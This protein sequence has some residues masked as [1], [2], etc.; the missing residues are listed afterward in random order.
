MVHSRADMPAEPVAVATAPALVTRRSEVIGGSREPRGEPQV[1]RDRGRCRDVR[2]LL[3]GRMV[4]TTAPQA[5]VSRRVETMD[6]AALPPFSNQRGCLRCGARYEI[7]VHFD[8]DCAA[9]RG[10]HF[11]RL[12]RCGHRWLERCGEERLT[13][14]IPSA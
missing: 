9:V 3:V 10:D 13:H 8:R 14:P 5:V 11:H 2:R 4:A 6:V 1:A 12:C 7:R